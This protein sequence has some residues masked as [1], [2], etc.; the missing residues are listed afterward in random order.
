MKSCLNGS[1]IPPSGSYNS[2]YLQFGLIVPRQSFSAKKRKTEKNEHCVYFVA[3]LA[4][5]DQI[6]FFF[7]RFSPSSSSDKPSSH[8]NRTLYGKY[9]ET[10]KA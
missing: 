2:K 7:H 10:L 1:I 9:A 6:L 3:I 8:P 4:S 5:K